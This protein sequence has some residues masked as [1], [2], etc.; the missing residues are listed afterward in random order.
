MGKPYSSPC[1]P[2]YCKGPSHVTNR[3]FSSFHCLRCTHYSKI[4]P[5]PCSCSVPQT[6]LTSPF[7]A[8][9]V[10]ERM[11]LSR[12]SKKRPRMLIPST[13]R[14]LSA[15]MDMMVSTHSYLRG[16]V[17]LSCVAINHVHLLEELL[18]KMHASNIYN[19]NLRTPLRQDLWT[20]TTIDI[21]AVHTEQQNGVARVL[22]AL[23]VCGNLA[24]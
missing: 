11:L 4:L 10:K 5:K 18:R 14:P 20:D 23:S 9:C 21:F 17:A 7:S 13:R 3:T 19:V 2:R 6:R 8:R 24:L 12:L 16:K 22:G 15:S 1:N